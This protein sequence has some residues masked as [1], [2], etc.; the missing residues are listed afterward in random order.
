MLCGG[1]APEGCAP[2]TSHEKAVTSRPWVTTTTDLQG[3]SDPT[4][5]GSSERAPWP[6]TPATSLL[7]DRV[8]LFPGCKN[9]QKNRVEN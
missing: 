6:A 3:H 5:T 8:S 4:C 7:L 2:R 1:G 9:Q